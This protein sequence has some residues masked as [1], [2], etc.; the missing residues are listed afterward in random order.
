[1]AWWIWVLI[2]V[3]VIFVVAIVIGIIVNKREHY[4]SSNLSNYSSSY[5][6]YRSDSPSTSSSPIRTD[7]W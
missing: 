1:M 5:K 4:E 7:R 3:G 2:I 6:N